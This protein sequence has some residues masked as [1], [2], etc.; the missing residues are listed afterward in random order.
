[1]CAQ[2]VQMMADAAGPGGM[3]GGQMLDLAAEA[4]TEPL[5]EAAIGQ[6]Q[7]MKTGALIRFACEAGALIGNASESDR[8]TLRAFG[9]RLG[10]LFQITDDLLDA[11]SDAATLGK[12]AGKDAARNKATLVSLLGIEGAKAL[13]EREEKAAGQLLAPFD[14]RASVLRDALHFACTRD[15]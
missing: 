13:R 8:E 7:A 12:A 2:L 10:F 6:L 4:A 15:H 1:V 14:E 9:E 11:Q 5:D 3:V